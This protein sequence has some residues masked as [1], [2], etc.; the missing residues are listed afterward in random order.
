MTSQVIKPRTVTVITF[1]LAVAINGSLSSPFIVA[2]LQKCGAVDGHITPAT[3]RYSSSVSIAAL[4][5]L[6]IN[7][8]V[9][10]VKRMNCDFTQMEGLKKAPMKNT[11]L[12][13][14]DKSA[15]RRGLAYI[16]GWVMA[17]VDDDT[18]LENQ[19]VNEV[20]KENSAVSGASV[21]SAV[22]RS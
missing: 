9:T 21:M 22:D 4:Q 18:D 17:I 20:A 16:A 14:M 6:G 19:I 11:L 7:P 8:V 10:G 15:T 12:T 2:M 1:P 3:F 13:I 5:R